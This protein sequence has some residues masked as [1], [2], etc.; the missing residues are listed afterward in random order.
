MTVSSKQDGPATGRPARTPRATDRPGDTS[1]FA[2]GLLLRRA[3]DHAAAALSGALR[4]LGVELRHFAVLIE[5][6]QSGPINQRDLGATIGMDKAMVVRVVDDLEK[7]GMAVRKPIP[8]DRRVREVEITP[9]GLEV[10]DAAHDN[11]QAIFQG[12]VEHLGDGEYDQL[13]DVLTRFTYP[14]PPEG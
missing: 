5:L 10:F 4:P 2:I 14:P 7:W 12:L 8:G 6:H 1:P 13:M 9:R 11:G 3:H